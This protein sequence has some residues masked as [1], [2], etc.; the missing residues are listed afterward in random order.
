MIHK[1]DK[2]LG[3]FTNYDHSPA[4]LFINNSLYIITAHTIYGIEPFNT[5]RKKEI[6]LDSIF[7]NFVERYKCE[8]QAYFVC[9]NHYHLLF[10]SKNNADKL[11]KIIA[12]IHRF[13]AIKVNKLDKKKGRQVWYQYWDTVITSEGSY[14]ARFNYIHHNPVKHGYVEKSEDY[15]FCSYKQYY[16]NDKEEVIKIMNKYPFDKVKVSEP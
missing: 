15:K 3:R 6:L 12:D 2:N 5:D 9:D 1:I 10:N 13:T 14:Y 16:E 7:L 11:P 4:H 8:M